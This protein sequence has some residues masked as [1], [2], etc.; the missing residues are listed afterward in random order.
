MKSK[1]QE[2][3]EFKIY[4]FILINDFFKN[5]GPLRTPNVNSDI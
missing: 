4:K 3:L 2:K 1:M 5:S